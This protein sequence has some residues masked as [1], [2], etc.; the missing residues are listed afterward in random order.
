MAVTYG[1]FNSVNGDRK[2][3]ADQM[4]AYFRGI[5]TQGVF[6]SLDG[7]LAVTAGTGLA[8]NVA[9]GR[10]IVQDKW[11]NNDLAMT[12]TIS[13]ASATYPRYDAV[14]IKYDGSARTVSIYVKAGTPAASPTYPTMT[15]SG[16]TY[17]MCLAYVSVPANAT[18]V[19]VTDKRSDTSVCGWATVA[20]S[21][22]GTYEAM[23]DDMK[24]G[25]DGVTYDSPGAAVRA[26]DG[27]LQ[28]EIDLQAH[29]MISG[30]VEITAKGWK[31]SIPNL[32]IYKGQYIG[33]I[34]QSAD[35]NGLCSVV[36]RKDGSTIST[37]G[38]I[39]G[40]TTK[41][42][43]YVASADIRNFSISH[44]C[45]STTGSLSVTLWVASENKKK[46]ICY[47]QDNAFNYTIENSTATVY[48]GSGI[49]IR[50][51]QSKTFTNEQ[52]AAAAAAG[53]FTF[54][55][56]NKTVTSN[57]IVIYYKADTDSIVFA[58]GSQNDAFMNE[59]I[60]LFYYYS[61]GIGGALVENYLA[62]LNFQELNNATTATEANSSFQDIKNGNLKRSSTLTS[63]SGYIYTVKSV[64]LYKGRTYEIVTVADDNLSGTS[65]IAI[66]QNGS[67][68][69]AFTQTVS[70]G[71]K[72]V[73]YYTPS[74]NLIDASI[75]HYCYSV[76]GT[77]SDTIS[78]VSYLDTIPNYYISEVN[79]AIDSISE[80][81]NTCG[82][83]GETFVFI[84][85]IHWETNTRHSPELIRYILDRLN[86]NKIICGGDLINQGAKSA[87]INTLHECV[88]SFN[89]KNTFF[90]I[91]FG[92]HDSNKNG[93]SS[94]DY[95]D[96]N[97]EYALLMKQCDDKVHYLNDGTD[98]SMYFDVEATKTRFIICDTGENGTFLS[99]DE[100][101]EC[102]NA[103]PSG[104]TVIIVAHWL[105]NENA[106]SAF[107]INLESIVDAYNGRE[108]V[109]VG[110]STYDFTSASGNIASVIAGHIHND[111][112]FSTSDGIPFIFTDCDNGPRSNNTSYP[113]VPGTITEQCFDVVT[114]DYTNKTVKCV[115][116]GRGADRNFTY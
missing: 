2:Y 7:G 43:G 60:I 41:V 38:D 1:F 4:S 55:S 57:N 40:T 22:S 81:M 100:L 27:I 112:D 90:P 28:G 11:V 66:R 91:A 72:F 31:T 68:I 5:V 105:Y 103:A 30:G 102:L 24:T 63:A 59:G 111:M 97:T 14:V 107:C 70:A 17:E 115:R 87:M 94:S 53:G 93:S 83:N 116:I 95:F 89:I 101:C 34:V 75:G 99:Y 10:A 113:Y 106:K 6:Q 92:N 62:G 3:D 18:S 16:T 33:V 46:S 50:G 54:D 86:I 88:R 64:N 96:M 69:Q 74:E 78:D 25:F 80:N 13:D 85:D 56:T 71:S 79:S 49:V 42:F 65:N 52:I 12:L 20:Q 37:L 48:I 45:G 36:V 76:T 98:W 104:Y 9:T 32:T 39:S 23:I 26:C 29:S 21:I 67:T 58:Q 109:T 35:L 15:R 110:G 82:K 77:I 44:Y 73:N 51:T 8:V 84:T 47:V 114:I 61:R 108:S 19:T